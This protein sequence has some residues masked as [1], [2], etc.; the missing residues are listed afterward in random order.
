MPIPAAAGF[1]AAVVHYYKQPITTWQLS[2][3]WLVVVGILGFLMISRMRYYS[4]KTLD[5]HKR[6]SY[7]GIILVGLII[8][9]IWL[10]SEPILLTLAV[11][12]AL[13]GIILRIT[14]KIRPHP[15]SPE[16]V[17]AS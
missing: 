10:F 14:A 15:P 16:E 12:Y 6:R 13:S 2:Y 4:F 11:T 5:L 1:V 7:L 8:L 3:V 17:H 9:F